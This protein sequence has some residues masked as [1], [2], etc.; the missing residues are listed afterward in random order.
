MFY[1][2]NKG[3]HHMYIIVLRPPKCGDA[4]NFA[5]PGHAFIY[6]LATD[7]QAFEKSKKQWFKN[8]IF[9]NTKYMMGS[10]FPL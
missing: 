3:E 8:Q 10:P 1:F 9:C 6:W 7:C 5:R 4:I 2:I